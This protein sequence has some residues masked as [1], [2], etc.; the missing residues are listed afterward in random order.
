MG[1]HLPADD[2]MPFSDDD[3]FPLD[4]ITLVDDDNVEKEFEVLD[5]IQDSGRKF[6]ALAL[7]AGSP[8][9]KSLNN[10]ANLA[11][12]ELDQGESS[13]NRFYFIFEVV[14]KNGEEELVE[15]IDDE[16]LDTLSKKFEA[17]LGNI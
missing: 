13:E 7:K 2:T 14:E 10:D 3:D 9:E 17:R 5:F 15:V 12:I 6:Y 8:E 1:E 4:T 16:L 11:E